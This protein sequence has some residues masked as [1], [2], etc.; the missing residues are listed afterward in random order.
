MLLSILKINHTFLMLLESM[1]YATGKV[2]LNHFVLTRYYHLSS[3]IAKNWNHL[4]EVK[5]L[6]LTEKH[7]GASNN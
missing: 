3:K 2:Q 5:E 7:D 1:L 6:E 4:R